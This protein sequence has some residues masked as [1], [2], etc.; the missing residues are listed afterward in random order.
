[1]AKNGAS[2]RVVVDVDAM[3][4]GVEIECTLPSQY[5][6][7][8]GIRVGRYHHGIELP[9]PFPADWTSQY[10][11]SLDARRGYTALEI[12]S[13]VLKGMAGLEQVLQVFNILNEAGALVNNSCGFHVHVGVRSVLGARAND[14]G[15]VVRWVRRMLHLVSVHELGLFAITGKRSRLDNCYCRTIKEQWDEVLET[16][17]GL[18]VITRKVADH[19]ERYHTLNLCNLTGGKRTVEFRLFGSTLNGMQAL[20]YII[21]ALGI[22]HRA[23]A[24]GVAPKFDNRDYMPVRMNCEKMVKALQSTLAGY[25]WPTGAKRRWGKAIRAAQR[26]AVEQFVA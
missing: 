2:R 16:T 8:Q 22:A 25:G 3:T 26:E 15:L 13:P 18:D 5:V 1:M 7:E 21:T 17:S 4:F 11:G 12:V 10:D 19:G 23:A 20:G 6:R 9:A 24:C 14:E